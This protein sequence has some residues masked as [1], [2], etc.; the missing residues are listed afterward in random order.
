[1]R[2][3]GGVKMSDNSIFMRV[4]E[5][6]KVLDVSESYAYKIIKK[7][8]KELAEKGKIVVSGRVNRK[9]FYKRIDCTDKTE[10]G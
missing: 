7:L 4:D 3:K 9:Y 1:V 10:G 8:N 5:V 6:A 2:A